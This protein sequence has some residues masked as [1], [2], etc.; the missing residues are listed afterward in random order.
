MKNQRSLFLH[1]NYF[2]KNPWILKCF[3]TS[4]F[5]FLYPN[6]W[7][8]SNRSKCLHKDFCDRHGANIVSRSKKI[9]LSDLTLKLLIY[10]DQREWISVENHFLIKPCLLRRWIGTNALQ[11]I[12]P[13]FLPELSWSYCSWSYPPRSPRSGV[14]V[15]KTIYLI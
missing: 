9:T 7:V 8:A 14:A 10:C 13:Q 6:E 2:Q 11:E 12:C 5:L 15:K 4:K 1:S 3:G